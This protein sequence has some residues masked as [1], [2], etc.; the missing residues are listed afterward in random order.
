MSLLLYSTVSRNREGVKLDK[1][2]KE[3][4]SSFNKISAFVILVQVLLWVYFITKG[5]II[6]HYMSTSDNVALMVLGF[7]CLYS[8]FCCLVFLSTYGW[9]WLNVAILFIVVFLSILSCIYIFDVKS[10]EKFEVTKTENVSAKIV[11]KGT[12]DKKDS[13]VLV[14]GSEVLTYKDVD[15]FTDFKNGDK[16]KSVSTGKLVITYRYLF[17]NTK[18]RTYN[19]KRFEKE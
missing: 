1:V 5:V 19:I 2:S 6:D 3:E 14:S 13:F 15:N 12:W 4:V 10:S 17:N 11:S 8:F 9:N 18:V 16:V 7:T